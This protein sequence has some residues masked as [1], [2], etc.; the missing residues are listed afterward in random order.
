MPDK[1]KH[2]PLS[3]R[4]PEPDREWLLAYAKR[5]DQAVNA[6]ITALVAEFRERH[7]IAQAP[8]RRAHALNCKCM[9]CKPPKDG[10]K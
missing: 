8:A 10:A 4:L 2:P 6:V 7:A 5:T 9:T 3:V 1:H